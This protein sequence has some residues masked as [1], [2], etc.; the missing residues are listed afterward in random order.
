MTNYPITDD[1]KRMIRFDA[2]SEK[3]V[4]SI[5]ELLSENS[6]CNIHDFFDAIKEEVSIATEK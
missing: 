6:D 5:I 2:Q 3:I 4:A 1:E